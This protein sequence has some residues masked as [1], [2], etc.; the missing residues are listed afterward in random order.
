[1]SRLN[2][3]EKREKGCNKSD[4]DEMVVFSISIISSHDSR[5]W[6]STKS[7][8]RLAPKW[9]KLGRWVPAFHFSAIADVLLENWR[10]S[11]RSIFR[12]MVR[13][14]R[15]LSHGSIGLAQ[16]GGAQES[17]I[18]QV[19]LVWYEAY[20]LIIGGGSSTTLPIDWYRSF[21]VDGGKSQKADWESCSERKWPE[22]T[23]SDVFVWIRACWLRS[24]TLPSSA[25]IGSLVQPTNSL[26]WYRNWAV[27]S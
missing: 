10:A 16:S 26:V 6:N 12:E 24:D 13:S 19:W 2:W 21:D 18:G 25:S 7:E 3:S 23:R 22:S 8:L 5:T 11:Q 1:M 4:N 14:T 20:I 15:V 17:F 27:G 9:H